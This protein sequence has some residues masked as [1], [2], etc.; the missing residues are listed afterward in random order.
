MAAMGTVEGLFEREYARL[1]RALAVAEDAP[2]A[3]DAVQE[4]FI[5]A[6]RRWDTVSRLEDPAGWVRR[7]AVNRLSNGRRNLRRQAEI[8][9]GI[10]P[11]EP[12]ALDPLDLDLLAGLRAL[13]P[14]QRMAVCLFHLAG[15]SIA[16]VADA[17][18]V[19][20]GTVKSTLHDARLSLRRHV[21]VVDDAR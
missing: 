13:P 10:R 12:A 6:D 18:G 1:V 2:H 3:A 19:A 15:C 21:E 20:E 8:L 4:A 5:E 7:V 17:M 16:Q 9:R 14:R 11:A